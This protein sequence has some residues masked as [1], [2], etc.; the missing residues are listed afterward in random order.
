[1]VRGRI[2]R[3]GSLEL[4]A[5]SPQLR[6][7]AIPPRVSLG[8]IVLGPRVGVGGTAVYAVHSSTLK[9]SGGYQADHQLILDNPRTRRKLT[10]AATGRRSSARGLLAAD[11]GTVNAL[12]PAVVGDTDLVYHTESLS[13]GTTQLIITDSSSSVSQVLLQS[14]D[15]VADGA[16]ITEILFGYHPTQVDSQG[17]L[18]F[19][20][21]FLKNPNGN[22]NDSSNIESSIVV[23]IPS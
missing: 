16:Q 18:A 15:T 19:A 2:D 1:L 22:P 17:R 6:A 7:G 13:D 4:L 23:G 8:D 9:R 21:E 14:G 11:S 3:P 5:I 10:I 12:S 20:A